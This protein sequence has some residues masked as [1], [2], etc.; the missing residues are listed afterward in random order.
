MLVVGLWVVIV[1]QVL[2]FIGRL[3][4][5]GAWFMQTGSKD[6]Q[7]SAKAAYKGCALPVLE[8]L[9]T[10]LVV[11]VCVAALTAVGTCS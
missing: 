8:L 9:R 4:I 6:K 11:G 1:V 10:V 5:A 2:S 3:F 7:K